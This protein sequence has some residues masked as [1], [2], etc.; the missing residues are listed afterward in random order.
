MQ[1]NDSIE[2]DAIKQWD[3]YGMPCLIRAGFT[4]LNGYVRLPQGKY[5][6]K[7]VER[8]FETHWGITYGPDEEGW[9]GF[10]TA[11]ANDY[12]PPDDLVSHVGNE[13]MMV[14]NTLREYAIKY[15]GG[16]RWTLDKL[17][18]ETES[19]AQQVAI[20]LELDWSIVPAS[21]ENEG[22]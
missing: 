4:S 1:E 16:R 3:A 9:I 21:K 20:A 19:L 8:I 15:G 2:Q 18:A 5:D 13:G 10:D 14:A 7:T 12:W 6:S 17:K 22:M 11:H